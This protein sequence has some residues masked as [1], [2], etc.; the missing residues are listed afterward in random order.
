MEF[1]PKFPEFQILKL[2][3]G[4]FL[5]KIY[6]LQDFFEQKVNFSW[7]IIEFLNYLL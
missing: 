2:S 5:C 4:K 6:Q 3:L 7:Q 1:F